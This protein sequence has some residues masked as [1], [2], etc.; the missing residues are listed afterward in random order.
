MRAIVAG[1]LVLAQTLIEPLVS[2]AGGGGSRRTPN[3]RHRR[4]PRRR[5]RVALRLEEIEHSFRL[6]QLC[7]LGAQLIVLLLQPAVLR[8]EGALCL[9]MLPVTRR[10]LRATRLDEV[11]A[12]KREARE[13]SGDFTDTG[14]SD[15][16]EE[17]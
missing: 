17:A 7:A 14:E 12:K 4:S 13:K 11:R 9:R 8:D 6:M 15:E 10:A 3:H 2:S 5:V 1:L 16:D